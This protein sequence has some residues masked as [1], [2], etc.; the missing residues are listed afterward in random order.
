MKRVSEEKQSPLI[1]ECPQCQH[2]EVVEI[3][4]PPP[5]P[6]TEDNRDFDPSGGI[7]PKTV[8]SAEEKGR[9]NFDSSGTPVSV[10][11]PEEGGKVISV[12]WILA[13]LTLV[14]MFLALLL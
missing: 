8:K 13:G 3:Q 14:S 4:L 2:R 9:T 11:D 12:G 5:W 7:R 10:G 1:M 6:P